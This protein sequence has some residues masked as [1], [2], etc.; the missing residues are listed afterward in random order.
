MNRF[1]LSIFFSLLLP[2]SLLYGQGTTHFTLSDTQQ[3]NENT[4]LATEFIGNNIDSALV[5]LNRADDILMELKKQFNFDYIPFELKIARQKGLVY[6]RKGDPETGLRTIEKSLKDPNGEKY[7][8]LRGKLY[9]MEG[10]IHHLNANGIKAK[11]SF[12]NSIASDSS[13]RNQMSNYNNLGNTEAKFKRPTQAIRYYRNT[14]KILQKHPDHKIQ[15]TCLLNIAGALLEIDSLDQASSS[16]EAASLLIKKHSLQKD[17]RQLMAY[18]NYATLSIFRGDSLM[19][20][21]YIDSALFISNQIG[22]PLL[23]QHS[24]TQYALALLAKNCAHLKLPEAIRAIE[25]ISAPL[26]EESRYNT[27]FIKGKVAYCVGDY[28]KAKRY[29]QKVI[30]KGGNKVPEESYFECHVML[31]DIY[32]KEGN[33]ADALIIKKA[34]LALTDSVNALKS[35]EALNNLT[36]EVDLQKANLQKANL[37]KSRISNEMLFHEKNAQLRLYLLLL[38]G[39]VIAVIT[40][41][42]WYIYRQRNQILATSKIIQS[43]SERLEHLV[44]ERNTLVKLISH[45]LRSHL[46][47]IQLTSGALVAQIEQ[48]DFQREEV[49]EHLKEIEESAK[50]VNEFSHRIMESSQID[51]SVLFNSQSNVN[52]NQQLETVEKAH[53]PQAN[54]K[55]IRIE[56]TLLPSHAEVSTD[57]NELQ[58]ILGNLISN[59]IKFSPRN[60]QVDLIL[61][62][63]GTAYEIIVRDQGPG[64]RD[65]DFKEVFSRFTPL[66][67]KPTANEESLG[68]GLFLAKKLSKEIGAGLRIENHPDGGAVVKLLIKK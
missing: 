7:P 49:K 67:A 12:L 17:V 61:K 65:D 44:S 11:R 1:L 25:K 43:T 36:L 8:A 53:S 22:N 6:Y 48:D 10:V 15:I 24:Y 30:S 34:H 63:Q 55:H 3:V 47:S 68:M 33:F 51:S 21:Q 45:D 23:S 27:D 18:R 13:W 28:Q 4:L 59:A 35:Q 40:I 5:L 32:E 26:P 50:S 37:Q 41:A 20:K 2:S 60:S 52:L 58:L 42:I 54:R 31:A 64:F 16:L 66:S 39:G 57:E 46:M 14:L 29:H 38:A 56:T 62:D 19:G 9:I